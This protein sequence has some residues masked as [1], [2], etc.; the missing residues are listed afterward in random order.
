[1]NLKKRRYNNELKMS[2]KGIRGQTQG[3]MLSIMCED[4]CLSI[5]LT[6]TGKPKAVSI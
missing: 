2:M 4:N 3:N 5:I 6:L 1:M